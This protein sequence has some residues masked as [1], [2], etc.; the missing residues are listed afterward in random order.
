MLPEAS[1]SL[2]EAYRQGTQSP[3][4][5]MV[6]DFAQDADDRLRYRTNF[7]PSE[8]PPIIYVRVND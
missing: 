6:L 7:F 5:Y 2:Y 1:A 8:Y 3:Y 4:G